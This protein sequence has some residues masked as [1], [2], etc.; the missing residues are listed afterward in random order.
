MNPRHTKPISSTAI[1][2]RIES[3]RYDAETGYLVIELDNSQQLWLSA[4]REG[5]HVF[6]LAPPITVRH[7]TS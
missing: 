7:T 5:Y 2:H 3:L 4:D 6:V 1:G